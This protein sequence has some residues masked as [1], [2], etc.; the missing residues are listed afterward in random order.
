M[1]MT[2]EFNVRPFGYDNSPIH[3]GRMKVHSAGSQHEYSLD[4]KT[5]DGWETLRGSIP[6]TQ[7]DGHKRSGH[8]NFL[9]L[10]ADILD[11][12]DLHGLGTNYVHILAEIEAAY[13]HIQGRKVGDYRDE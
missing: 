6:K 12:I 8:R 5:K 4:Y 9:H 2:F 11:D 7:V 10:M 13:P 1:A 3:F